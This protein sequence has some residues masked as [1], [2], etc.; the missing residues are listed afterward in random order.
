MTPRSRIFATFCAALVFLRAPAS[1]GQADFNDVGKCMAIALQ[2]GHFARQP[3][4]RLSS[5]FLEN[6]LKALDPGKLFFTR[7][8]IDRFEQSYGESLDDLLLKGECMTA[9]SDISRT[10]GLRVAAR[11]EEAGR[12]LAAPPFDFTQDESIPASRKDATWP[13]DESQAMILWRQQV[14]EALLAEILR[15][16]AAVPGQESATGEKSPGEKLAA[17]YRR[18]LAD[19]EADS[20][21]AKVASTFLSSVAQAFDPHTDY[22]NTRDVELFNEDMRNEIN[23]IGVGIRAD[24]NGATLIRSVVR[25]GPADRQGSLQP[26]D[27]VIAIDPDGEGPRESLDI[28]FMGSD[29]V[30]ELIR[31]SAGT[32]V[33]LSV[34]PAT[35]APG[36]ATISILRGQVPVEESLA[37]AQLIRVKGDSGERKLGLITLPSFYR[38]FEKSR[39]ACSLDV[40]KLLLRLKGEAIDGLL[41]DLRG[42]GGGSLTEVERMT[43]FFTRPSPVVQVKDGYGKIAVL[44]STADDPLYG[45]PLVVLTDRGSASASEIFAAALQDDN[46]AVIVGEAATFGKGTVQ[47]IKDLGSSMPFFTARSGAGALRLTVQKFYRPSGLSTQNRGVIPDIVLPGP[48]DGRERGESDLDFALGPDRIALAPAFHPLDRNRLFIPELAR[49]SA[50][51]VAASRDFTYLLE[52]AQR[53]KQFIATNRVSLN[54]ERRREEIGANAATAKERDEERRVRFA[55]MAAADG[56]HLS[57]DSFTLADLA[58]GAA[59]RQAAPEPL[60]EKDLL[61]GP[62][63]PWPGGLDPQKRE[64]I[65]VLGDLIDATGRAI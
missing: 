62:A 10:F 43:G 51:R 30:A 64:A 27:R 52:D 35:G 37:S 48:G 60:P 4:S 1:A 5:R 49:K 21:P 11:V 57:I 23:G 7:Q 24:P 9:A 39:T 25:N 22:M 42:N 12:L 50:A 45:G 63:L 36:A 29:R 58:G 44:E 33:T 41:I 2:N 6:Y 53:L 31:G 20:A 17:R 14:K 13:R 16:E 26:G 47:V 19:V 54:L 61:S 34:E 18:V 15:R 65:A 59:L 38:D 28:L 3:F 55:G 46:R 56:E 40:E 32:P 8:D